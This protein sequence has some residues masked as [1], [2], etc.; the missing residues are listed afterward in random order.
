MTTVAPRILAA[1]EN[2]VPREGESTDSVCSSALEENA[3]RSKAPYPGAMCQKS[4]ADRWV[5]ERIETKIAA[6]TASPFLVYGI[7]S[8]RVELK[9]PRID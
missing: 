7:E 6:P 4:A 8:L 9:S 5:S 3:C 1:V 2:V